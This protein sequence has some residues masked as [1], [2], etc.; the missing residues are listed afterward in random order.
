MDTAT[1]SARRGRPPLPRPARVK[2][3]LMLRADQVA[4]MDAIAEEENIPRTFVLRRAI[5][6]LLKE[7]KQ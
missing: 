4:G 1:I 6:L 7:K 3:T 5:D 2:V